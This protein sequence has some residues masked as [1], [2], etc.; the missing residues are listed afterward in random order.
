M[1]Y[2]QR[3]GSFEF[4]GSLEKCHLSSLSAKASSVMDKL[5]AAFLV[6]LMLI[7]LG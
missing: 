5:L 7:G 6:S 1:R 3:P 2:G 4:I